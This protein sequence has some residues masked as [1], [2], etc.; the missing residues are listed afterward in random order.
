M[1]KAF[2]RAAVLAS[3][4][5]LAACGSG[6]TAPGSAVLINTL[7]GQT[8][9]PVASTFQYNFAQIINRS[10]VAAGDFF[11][12][13]AQPPAAQSIK[14][15]YDPAACDVARALAALITCNGPYS[16]TLDPEADLAA[17]TLYSICLSP[18]IRLGTGQGFGGFM[19][20]FTTGGGGI[21]AATLKLIRLDGA[22]IELTAR[23]IPLRVGVEATFEG[24]V[25]DT[26]AVEAVT[27]ITDDQGRAVAGVFSW[28]AENTVMTFQPSTNF[29]YRTRYEVAIA[30]PSQAA[31]AGKAEVRQGF[32]TMTEGDVNGDGL[33][34]VLSS[35]QLITPDATGAVYLFSG[36]E[37][38]STTTIANALAAVLG[39]T[40][41]ALGVFVAMAG[42]V[43]ADGYD[44]VIATPYWTDHGAT[45]NTGAVYVFSGR[46][47]G[48][49][50]TLSNAMAAIYGAAADEQFGFSGIAGA[51]DFN[52]DGYADIVAT[53]FPNPPGTY[54]G[55][56]Y[57]FSGRD[58][59]QEMTSADAVVK[60]SGANDGDE[61]GWALSGIGDVNGDGF[62][63]VLIG[64]EGA[65]VGGH[66]AAGKAYLFSGKGITSAT[67]IGDAFATIV[68]ATPE[69]KIYMADRASGT[70]D[71]DG[72]GVPDIIIGAEGE[73]SYTGAAY[74]F[75]GAALS[76]DMTT[77]AAFARIS[78]AAV[79][80]AFGLQVAGVGDVDG[81]G[82][83]DVGVGAPAHSCGKG[84]AYVFSGAILRGTVG[85]DAALAA[86]VGKNDSDQAYL[87]GGAGDINGD[88]RADIAVGAYVFSGANILEGMLYVYDGAALSPATTVDNALAAIPG[89]SMTAEMGFAVGSTYR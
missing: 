79:D 8:G 81:D 4:F 45:L 83:N 37:I 53:A 43:N 26:A 6:A 51:G 5:G 11:I 82:L 61:F 7:D 50:T 59:R 70:G 67:T 62:G 65:T 21:P 24:A 29:R 75:S 32:T 17:N 14:A 41:M 71:V 49:A 86:I 69:D 18:E 2:A 64:A 57:F 74:L 77:A 20:S 40:D 13:P 31:F 1:R 25:T 34:D 84:A 28:N 72:D 36:P 78:G 76:G 63:D 30:P 55:D 19:A 16:C 3:I 9:I 12:V 44:D 39:S 33:S 88:G 46:D 54:R 80:D 85:T 58:L 15:A 56:V 42:D 38:G 60:V 47:L 89:G 52:N 23:P 10:S 87:I 68:S 27:S 35:A 66:G 22:K 73:E 48:S